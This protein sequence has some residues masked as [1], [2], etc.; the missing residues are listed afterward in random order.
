MIEEEM[1]MKKDDQRPGITRSCKQPR[2]KKKG[3]GKN[4]E[5]AKKEIHE[6]DTP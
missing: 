5:Q 4:E 2:T 6:V 3:P 1:K